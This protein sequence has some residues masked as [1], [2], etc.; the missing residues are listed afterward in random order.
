MDLQFW[1]VPTLVPW[2][3]P[4]LVPM[5][6]YGTWPISLL[7]VGVSLRFFLLKIS[8]ISIYKMPP[9]LL[10]NLLKVP[11]NL[12]PKIRK[13]GSSPYWLPGQHWA[14]VCKWGNLSHA[15][16][17]WKCPN[18]PVWRNGKNSNIP[19]K[20]LSGLINQIR[21]QMRWHLLA[22]DKTYLQS[23]G[24]EK[25]PSD[26]REIWGKPLSVLTIMASWSW[27]KIS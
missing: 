2:L 4:T 5:C 26:N 20:L 16:K 22:T 11:R 1:L 15:H 23:K 19:L 3:V 25:I 13:I 6:S 12:S 17:G 10:S 9:C 8:L 18:Q 7:S 21:R 24:F 27:L 14:F